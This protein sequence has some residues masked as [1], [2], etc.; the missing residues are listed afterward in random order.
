VVSTQ[1]TTRYTGRLFF[2]FFFFK[3]RIFL[4]RFSVQE[5]KT[6]AQALSET[7]KA[8][9]QIVRYIDINSKICHKL[10]LVSFAYACA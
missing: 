3:G 7:G 8:N 10:P 9:S 6:E 5:N 4:F 2:F 1:S